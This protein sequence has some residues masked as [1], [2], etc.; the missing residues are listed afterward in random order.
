[1][2]PIH[3]IDT[4]IKRSEAWIK[5]ALALVDGSAWLLIAPALVA[6]W[7][8]DPPTFKALV[9]WSVFMF[10]LA[11]VAIIVSRVVF[12]RL[13]LN[14]FIDKA[15]AGDRACAHVAAAVILFV[16]VVMFCFV[17]WAKP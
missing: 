12:P 5:R 11:G 16:G 6:L 1:M 8:I 9:Q 15:L 7:F 3:Q 10:A 4:G 2:D 17:H 13:N 14:A